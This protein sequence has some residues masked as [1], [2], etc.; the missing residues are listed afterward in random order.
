[1]TSYKFEARTIV[2]ALALGALILIPTAARAQSPAADHPDRT[3]DAKMRAAVIEKVIQ[4]LNQYYIDPELARKMEESLRGKLR[5]GAFDTLVD[6]VEP[7][8]SDTLIWAQ[9]G[10]TAFRIRMDGQARVHPGDQIKIGIDPSR[11]SLFDKK[12]EVRL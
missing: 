5:Q 9:L 3:V 7:M 1:M 8:G 6:L 11:A 10:A 2:R 12:S 4:Q